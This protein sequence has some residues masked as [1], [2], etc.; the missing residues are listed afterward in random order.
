[1]VERG[2]GAGELFSCLAR[3][4]CRASM[5]VGGEPAGGGEAELAAAALGERFGIGG[6]GALPNLAPE[7]SDARAVREAL[8]RAR[9]AAAGDSGFCST[10]VRWPIS[11]GEKRLSSMA[12]EGDLPS[13][14]ASSSSR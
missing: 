10:V 11:S 14:A 8:S 2:L 3:V 1:M 13:P 5:D 12:G 6:G 9:S 4:A 7:G